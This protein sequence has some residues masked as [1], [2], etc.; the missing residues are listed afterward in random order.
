MKRAR[1]ILGVI[2]GLMLLAS[3]ARTFDP[4]LE[5]LG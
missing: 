1:L 3:S 5:E 2:A 4:G